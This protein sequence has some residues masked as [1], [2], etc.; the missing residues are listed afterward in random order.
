V[1]KEIGNRDS[2]TGQARIS[3]RNVVMFTSGK[4]GGSWPWTSSHPHRIRVSRTGERSFRNCLP[5]HPLSDSLARLL[6]I[7]EV[8]RVSH[9]LAKR[10]MRNPARTQSSVEGSYDRR[11]SFE[12]LCASCARAAKNI[13]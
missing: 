5:E 11:E 8:D 13:F 2:H 12:A 6:D 4:L 10:G 1:T 9:S 7:D 3:C